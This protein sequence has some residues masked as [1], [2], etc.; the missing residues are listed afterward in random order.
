MSHTT[1]AISSNTAQTFESGTGQALG[2]VRAVGQEQRGLGELELEQPRLP[3]LAANHID[4]GVEQ[5]RE[6]QHREHLFGERALV[7]ARRARL[8]LLGGKQ[9]RRRRRA[10]WQQ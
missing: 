9:V 6:W 7:R 10:R 5:S 3:A 4:A 1:V 2:G 8:D